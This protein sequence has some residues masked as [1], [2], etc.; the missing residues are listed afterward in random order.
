M[1]GGTSKGLYFNAADLPRDR[2]LRDRVLLAAMGSPDARQID[3]AGGAHPLTSKVAVISPSAH[4]GA[5]V[6]YL[7]LQVVVDQ[8]SV[9]DSQNCGN[10]LAGVGPWAIENGLVPVAGPT[11]AVRIHMVNTG[12]LAVAHVHT[13]LG[14]VEYEGDARIDGVP[15]TAAPVTLEFLD[16]AGSSSGSLLP[17]GAVTDTFEGIEV[18]CIDNGMPVIIVRASDL[19]V[20]GAESPAQLEA[21]AAL[22]AKVERMRL[23][24]GPRM[25]LGD[26]TRKTIPK[27]SLVSAP[28]HGGSIG[29]VT[30][31]PH[32]VHEAIGVLG[33]VSVATACAIPGS[34]A[35]QVAQRKDNAFGRVEVEHP[36]GFFTV[37]VEVERGE[38]FIVRGAALL[39]TARKIL[40]GD[41]FVPGAVW[42]RA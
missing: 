28:R 19:G 26:V 29:T 24:I 12:S 5:D 20:T 23:H 21:N 3:G 22:V 35:A 2:E 8:A 17:T 10:I 15:G 18:T 6:D 27:I 13:P 39:R 25:N 30:F 16:V 11:T 41:V 40:R 4:A 31:I 34:V 38:S 33:A 36:S 32:R 9:S 14:S 37:D 7:F 1:R 42:S